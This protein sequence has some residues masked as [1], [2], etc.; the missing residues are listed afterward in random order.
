[1]ARKV[2]GGF[3]DE[4]LSLYTLTGEKIRHLKSARPGHVV[5]F[6]TIYY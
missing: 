4:L 1:M 2:D 6:Y 3:A 5:L